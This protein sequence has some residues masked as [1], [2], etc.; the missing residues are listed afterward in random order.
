METVNFLGFEVPNLR[1]SDNHIVNWSREWPIHEDTFAFERYFAVRGN[2]VQ[3]VTQQYWHYCFPI[4]LAYIGII[5]GLR[6]LMNY[7]EKGFNLRGPLIVWNIILALFSI[8]G[9]YRCLPEFVSIIA[10]EGLQAS[11]T[12]SSYYDVS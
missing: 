9:T 1:Y 8:L 3:Y 10:N 6:A 11:Y 12:K 4:S 7:R 2:Q 5:F